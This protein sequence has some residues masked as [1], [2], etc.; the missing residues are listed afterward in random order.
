MQLMTDWSKWENIR[1]KGLIRFILVWGVLGWGFSTGI[2]FSLVFSMIVPVTLQ[3]RV[4]CLSI[5]AFAFAGLF[6]GATLW[7]V[8]EWRYRRSNKQLT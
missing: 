5:P 8:M 3:A 7:L 4:W 1:R 2:I 6:F